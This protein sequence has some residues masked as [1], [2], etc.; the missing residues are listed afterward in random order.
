LIDAARTIFASDDPLKINRRLFA[1][2]AGVDPNLVRYYFGDMRS[3]IG[4]VL[5]E[6]HNR[7]RSEIL[8]RHT[9]HSDTEETLRYRIKKTFELFREQPH[10]HQ[11]VRAVIY[12]NP[13]GKDQQAWEALLR[14]AVADLQ[15]VLSLGV[16]RGQVRD[17][18]DAAALHVLIIAACEFWTTNEPVLSILFKPR[19]PG[20]RLD[21]YFVA[22]L[23]DIVMAALRPGDG[24]KSEPVACSQSC[25]RP[26]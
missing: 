24:S 9:T 8:G 22:F 26:R 17:G 5:A 15:D 13:D 20:I 6:T 23:Q 1:E 10:H 25:T 19:K 11:M 4:E 12:D 7:A 3:L 16:S 18:V 2:K 21:N 14:D